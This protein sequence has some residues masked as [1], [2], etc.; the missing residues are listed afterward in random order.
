M[1]KVILKLPK[2]A[3]LKVIPEE[4]I[5]AKLKANKLVLTS[6]QKIDIEYKPKPKAFT[7]LFKFAR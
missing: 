4:L 7:E 5:P 3:E 1:K 6:V 2:V